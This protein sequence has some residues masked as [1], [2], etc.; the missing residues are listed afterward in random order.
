MNVKVQVCSCRLASLSSRRLKSS[1][2]RHLYLLYEWRAGTRK[3]ID[4]SWPAWLVPG[5]CL[6]TGTMAG[7]YIEPLESQ[8][9]YSQ[10]PDVE[11]V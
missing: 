2:G 11:L 9:S 7:P 3:A 5:A 8:K 1:L 10:C 4:V 6:R